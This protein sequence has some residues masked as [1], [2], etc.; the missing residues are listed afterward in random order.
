MR[1]G[2]NQNIRAEAIAKRYEGREW[3]EIQDSIEQKFGL[4]PSIRQMQKWFEDYQATTDDPTGGKH[5]TKVIEDVAE[6]AKPVAQAK[7]ML[8]VMPLW[9]KLQEQYNMA[10]VDASW[11]A[12]LS[13]FEAQIGR[14]SFDRIL[15]KYREIRDNIKV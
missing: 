8:D 11:I 6:L 2:Y 5:I 14:R 3:K 15:K 4:K 9:S 13:F 7:M 10:A 12:I 1:R